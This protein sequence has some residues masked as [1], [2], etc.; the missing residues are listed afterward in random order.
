ML[1]NDPENLAGIVG[2][3]IR[4]AAERMGEKITD[5]CLGK[6]ELVSLLKDVDHICS[7]A[8]VYIVID[9][10]HVESACVHGHLD[11]SEKAPRVPGSSVGREVGL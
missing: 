1:P 11:V 5:R 10:R 4:A 9:S 7:I 3:R 6:L 8:C 2:F